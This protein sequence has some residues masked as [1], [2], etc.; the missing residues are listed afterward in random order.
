VAGDGEQRW[1]TGSRAEQRWVAG[2]GEQR[3]VTGSRAELGPNYL[4]IP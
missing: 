1:V 4:L 3:W 2:D